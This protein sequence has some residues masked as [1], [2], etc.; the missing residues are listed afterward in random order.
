[1]KVDDKVIVVTGASSGIGLAIA[2]ALV[3]EGARVAFTARSADRL[4]AEVERAMLGGG[5][6]IAVPMDVTSDGSVEAAIEV[7]LARYG[8]VDVV[9]NNAGNAGE[10]NLWSVTSPSALRE[11]FDVHLLGTERVMRAVLPTMRQQG[12]G[13]IVNFAST[14]AWVPM[15]GVAAYSAAKAAVVSFSEALREEL[16]GEQID[17]RVFAPPHTSTEAG[18][19]MPLDLPKIFEPDWVASE[20][21]AFLRGKQARALPGGNGMLLFIQRLSP[22]LASRIMSGL[23]FKALAKVGSAEPPRLAPPAGRHHPG[24]GSR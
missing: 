15:P 10:M 3:R 9:V 4:K 12:G 6:A 18:K 1:V 17:V 24:A 22:R 23:G 11:M 8:R 19:R 5:D 7:V 21:V 2:H 20:L 16:K 14:V 13:M